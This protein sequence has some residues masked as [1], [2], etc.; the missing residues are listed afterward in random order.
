[1]QNINCFVTTKWFFKIRPEVSK[2]MCLI[3]KEEIF[4]FDIEYLTHDDWVIIFQNVVSLC[5]VVH[6]NNI[7]CMKRTQYNKYE[8]STVNTDDLVN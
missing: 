6:C 1:M 2:K 7:I 3:C 5:N 8:V 4:L